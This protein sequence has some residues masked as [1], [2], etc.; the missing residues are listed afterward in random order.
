[1]ASEYRFLQSERQTTAAE[2]PFSTAF[3]FEAACPG[4]K[5]LHVTAAQTFATQKVEGAIGTEETVRILSKLRNAQ[6]GNQV[7]AFD[8]WP[9]D[10]SPNLL[11]LQRAQ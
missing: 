5:A 9:H 3:R 4:A 1:M 2:P 6:H 8:A 11:F 10:A 7:S